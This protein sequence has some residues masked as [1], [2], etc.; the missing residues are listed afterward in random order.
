MKVCIDA[1]H[2]GHDSG[3]VGCKT[4]EKWIALD[5]AS[6][7]ARKLKSSGIDV[8]LTRDEDEYIELAQR[9]KIAN[10]TGADLFLSLHCN[11]SAPT[12]QG[13]EIWTYPNAV[14]S[15]KFAEFLLGHLVAATGRKSRGVKHE[16]FAVLRLTK[17]PAALVELGF[18]SNAEEEQVMMGEA[19]QEDASEAIIGAIKEYMG[20]DTM[21]EKELVEIND[22]V[23][24]L[25]HRG[26]ITN[27]ILWLGKLQRDNDSYW[28]ARKCANALRVK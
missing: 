3:A 25:A 15:Q 1:G 28:L 12:A 27:K 16:D 10:Q 26:I 7:V 17:C 14:E 21:E 20:V 9:A 22:I 23:W 6:R 13:T 11:S 24:E 8:V 4:Y 19:Y 18:I 2:G 5:M